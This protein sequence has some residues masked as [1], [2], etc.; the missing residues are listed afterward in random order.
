MRPMF[1]I[2]SIFIVFNA[3][4]ADEASDLKLAKEL[5]QVV[6]DTKAGTRTRIEASRMLGR[7]G[8]RASG[9]VPDLITELNQ[10]KWIE[11]EPL[12]E[13]VIESIGNIGGGANAALPALARH[14]GRSLDL[15]Q[16]IKVAT[17]TILGS[18]EELGISTLLGQ[19]TAT[20]SSLRLRAIKAIARLGPVNGRIALRDLEQ[21]LADLDTDVR[22]AAIEAMR[23]IDPVGTATKPSALF[24]SAIAKDLA[25]P[26]EGIRFRAARQLGRIG[27]A[28][29]IVLPALEKSLDDQDK[30]VRRAVLDAMGKINPQP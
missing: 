2:L 3:S 23:Q 11:N 29:V 16:A 12:Q 22:R 30:E 25:D 7:L 17:K 6:R 20:D 4:F 18:P 15:D 1:L 13:A 27:P 10:Y 14:A 8:T 21:M 26:D 9:V 28:A 19:L 5:V 24:I